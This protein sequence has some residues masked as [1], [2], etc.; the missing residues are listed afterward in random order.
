MLTTDQYQGCSFGV[1][2]DQTIRPSL[3]TSLCPAYFSQCESS[4]LNR[5]I[6]NNG[7]FDEYS[8]VD[9]ARRGMKVMIMV[10]TEITIGLRMGEPHGAS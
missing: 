7:W 9:Y 3:L 5:W 6:W 2:M 8:A 1:D 4:F 10:G